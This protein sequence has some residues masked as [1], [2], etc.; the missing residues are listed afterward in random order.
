[1]Q[2]QLV[3]SVPG[4]THKWSLWGPREAGAERGNVSFRPEKPQKGQLRAVQWLCYFYS[5]VMPSKAQCV[6]YHEFQ[7]SLAHKVTDKVLEGATPGDHQS[8]L[9]VPGHRVGLQIH[10]GLHQMKSGD[11]H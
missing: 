2:K 10:S 8:A 6:I 1:M 3:Q 4:P 7:L 9:P 5:V 11:F